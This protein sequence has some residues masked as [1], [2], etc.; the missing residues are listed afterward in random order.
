LL[1]GCGLGVTEARDSGN[2]RRREA[3]IG[4]G[5]GGMG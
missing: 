5:H 2:E 3:Q 4:K 1:N